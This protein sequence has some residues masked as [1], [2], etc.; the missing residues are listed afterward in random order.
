M[1][2]CFLFSECFNSYCQSKFCR[3]FCFRYLVSL[4]VTPVLSLLGED[5]LL[6]VKEEISYF[7][8]GIRHFLGA[9]DN[10]YLAM[11]NEGHGGGNEF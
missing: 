10:I 3:S 4:C 1:P 6:S 2:K 7:P 5:I 8:Q 11:G 9:F